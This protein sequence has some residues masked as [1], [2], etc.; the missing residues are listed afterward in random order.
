[1][2]KLL[3]AIV[4]LLVLGVSAAGVMLWN[5]DKI[6]QSFKPELEK[7]ASNASGAKVTI[8]AL[9]V[10]VF[11][12]AEISLSE[13][14]AVFPNQP[15]KPLTLSKLFLQVELSEL[16]SGKLALRALRATPLDALQISLA[17]DAKELGTPNASFRGDGFIGDFDLPKLFGAMSVASP[18]PNPS[19]K[20][21]VTFKAN[22][23][24]GNVAAQLGSEDLILNGAPLQLAAAVTFAN[25]SLDVTNLSLKGFGGEVL[26]NT[27]LNLQH[28]KFLA[29]SELNAIDLTQMLT[30]LK[31]DMVQVISGTLQSFKADVSGLLGAQLKQSLAGKGSIELRNGK[32]IGLNLAGDVL[33]AVTNLPFIQ[34]SLYSKVPQEQQAALSSP[35]TTIEV[36]TSDFALSNQTVSTSN[37]KLKSAVFSLSGNGSAGFDGSVNMRATIY[38]APAFSSALVGS[39]KELRGMLDSQGQLTFVIDIRGTAPNFQIVPDL[40]ELLTKAGAQ[41]LGNVLEKALGGGKKDGGKGLGGLLGF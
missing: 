39:V 10:S 23:G 22:G 32:L 3:I 25:N 16:L 34:G 17:G 29:Q 30:A 24:L 11:P 15:E 9:A 37:L 13:L 26:N 35:D 40:S 18:M 21:K 2:R 19:L 36:M 28:S 5:L 38:F 20:G 8:G 12:S 31:P 14:R 41:A 7:I 1:M 6:V 27:K 4:V 33:K